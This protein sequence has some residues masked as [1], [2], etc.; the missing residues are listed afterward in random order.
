[1]RALLTGVVAT[2]EAIAVALASLLMVAAFAFLVW[3][4]AFDL[5]AEPSAVFAGAGAAWLLAHFIPLSIEIPA[6][7]MQMF[8]FGA[9]ALNF[10]LSLAPLGITLVTVGFALRAGWRAAARGGAG[11]AA[12][13]G[14]A[15]GFGAVTGI[16]H[17]AV[18]MA[19]PG[20]LAT[21]G[22][23]ALLYGASSG[24]AFMVRAARDEHG[25]WVSVLAAFET[26]LTKVRVPRPGVWPHRAGQVLRLAAMLVAAYTGLAAITLAIGL[27]S[28]FAVIIA[29]SEALQLDLW[30]AI[31]MFVLQ[32]TLL[33]VLLLWS[34][35]WLS[36]AGFA[37]G[38]G[39]S[40]SPFGQLLGPMPGI[41]VLAAIPDGWGSA[42]V[43]APL[44]LGLAGIGIGIALGEIAKR[45]TL[46]RLAIQV[47]LA[48]LLAGLAIALLN[49]ASGGSMG[50]GRLTVVGPQVWTAAGLAA[51]ELGIGC[52][53]GALAA[54]AD[55]ARR[56]VAAP[57]A[58]ASRLGIGDDAGVEVGK[59]AGGRATRDALP[60]ASSDTSGDTS[61]DTSRD[62]SGDA[63]RDT[64]GDTSRDAIPD[65]SS[66]TGASL[67]ST[68]R[69][70]GAGTGTETA[71]E[72][73]LAPVTPFVP[74]TGPES[75]P[76]RDAARTPNAQ[77]PDQQPTEPLDFD[78][79]E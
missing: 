54:R 30:G 70:R 65:A 22:I 16:V 34:G 45:Q 40:A 24:A 23:G 47:L 20:W 44:L 35:A 66:E 8:G 17:S 36:G 74:R 67:P 55:I 48:T 53:L 49:W 13:L 21:A 75:T 57:A 18:S 7:A 6:E 79:D 41:P 27:F 60:D 3:W 78:T 63:I 46:A 51:A 10:T 52:F 58:V 61:G 12:V 15:L 11:G 76:W 69:T 50:P 2:I 4:L 26:M 77:V 71:S 9:D 5:A 29:A 33:P 73:K 64:S 25:W 39:S 59:R 56:V 28:R 14:G 31:L 19:I 62:T 43:F 68:A 38:V 72:E 32:L 1:M 37:V 42:A